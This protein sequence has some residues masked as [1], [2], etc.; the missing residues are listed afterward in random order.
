MN[1][2]VKGIT[3]ALI[4]LGAVAAQAQTYPAKQ[5]LFVSSVQGGA[6]EAIQRAIFEKV[7]ENTGAT[8]VYE[9]R[10]GGGGAPALQALK[11]AAPDGYTLGVTYASAMNLNPLINKDLGIDPLKDFRLIT[12]LMTLGVVIA[13]REELPAKDI[14]ELVAMAKTKPESVRIGVFG[15][16][17]KSWVAMLEE[18]TGTKFLQ[19]PFKSST[20][21]ITAT[22]G[23]HIDAHFETVGTLVGQKGKLKALAYGGLAPSPQ[24]P[25]TVPLIRNLYQFDTLSWFGVL[26][27]QAAPQAVAAWVGRELVRAVKDPKIT[28]MIESAG[29]TVLGNTP[30]EFAAM[31]R[32]EVEGN[33]EIVR[34]YPDIR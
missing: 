8:F 13:A 22:L 12:N 7:K 1:H 23:G 9:G 15:A 17:N 6:P 26:A 20:E 28:G 21:S 5:V 4:A 29:F 25:A 33:A 16:G 32:A 31:L 11:N 18:R 30:E 34:K 2:L 19:V 24:L 3:A 14:R 10:G 27:P